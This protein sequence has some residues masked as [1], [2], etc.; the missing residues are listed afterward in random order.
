MQ[1]ALESLA[2]RCIAA[3]LLFFLYLPVTF[4]GTFFNKN[5]H[6]A[7][8]GEYLLLRFLATRRRRAID[9]FAFSIYIA[10]RK[11]PSAIVYS[12]L[13]PKHGCPY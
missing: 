6:F 1:S 2:E 9:S 11:Y 8:P 3:I 10:Y 7:S 12:A 13:L 5:T 4:N